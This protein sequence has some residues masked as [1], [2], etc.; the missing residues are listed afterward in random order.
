MHSSAPHWQ[1]PN[2]DWV[3]VM[4]ANCLE[5]VFAWHLD[6]DQMGCTVNENDSD[7]VG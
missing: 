6:K 3:G 7:Q 5:S 2:V 4:E 1:H